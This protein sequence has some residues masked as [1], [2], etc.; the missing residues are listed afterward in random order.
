MASG[1]ALTTV[2]SAGEDGRAL[3]EHAWS[4]VVDEFAAAE[5]ALSRFMEGSEVS[6]LNRA[7]LRGAPLAVGRRLARAAHA[8]DR[9]Q[10]VTGGRF[11]PRVLGLLDGWGY[12]G[13]SLGASVA[14][15][16]VG[17]PER[18]VERVDRWRIRLPHPID[19][20]GIGKGLAVRWAADR[21]QRAGVGR[22][23]LDAGG[24][25]VAHGPGPDGTPWMIGVED[26][27]GGAEPRAV[28]GLVDGAMATS[29]IRR[30]QWVADGR[31]RHHLVDPATSEPADGGL[32]AVTV[33]AADPAWA[34]VWSKT[35]FIAG[36]AGIA[37]QARA[38]GLA[39]WWIAVDGALEMTPA[40]RARTVWVA[41]ES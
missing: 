7:S 1:L 13:A 16:A 36:R 9:A 3:A 38:R 22:F 24:D 11:D 34:E 20:G 21:V 29:S 5:D 12:A 35:L 31:S 37:A 18:I 33:A 2:T 26:P 32:V 17:A 27:A 8:A 25:L 15:T 30:L 41:G 14:V 4:T 28:V 6:A 23:L 39:A 10:R 40:A 19:L